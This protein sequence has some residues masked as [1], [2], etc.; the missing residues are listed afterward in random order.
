MK[1]TYLSVIPALLLVLIMVFTAMTPAFADESEPE[2]DPEYIYVDII[3]LAAEFEEFESLGEISD[4][5]IDDDYISFTDS[6]GSEIIISRE[7]DPLDT[8]IFTLSIYVDNEIE[9]ELEFDYS[10]RELKIDGV[11]VEVADTSAAIC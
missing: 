6:D 11:S 9:D 7:Y 4:L 1:K 3:D 5:V 2:E 10:G 8:D